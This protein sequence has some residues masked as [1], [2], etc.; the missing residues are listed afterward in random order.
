MKKLLAIVL[1][2]TLML[3]GMVMGVAAE[4]TLLSAPVDGAA[5]EITITKCEDISGWVDYT[6]EGL[7]AFE[8]TT[9]LD[10]EG[11]SAIMWKYTGV[12][13]SNGGWNRPEGATG[14][15]INWK[16]PEGAYDI[17]GMNYLVMDLYV[18]HPDLIAGVRFDVELTSSGRPDKLEN[19][20]QKTLPALAGTTLLEGWNHLEIPL[21]GFDVGKG[22][23]QLPLEPTAWNFIR[24]Y[25][26]DGF[27]T[28]GET[29]VLAVK[30]L[31]FS[32]SSPQAEAAQA[33]AQSVLDLY[34]PLADISTGDITAD[35]Y[36]TVK[37]QLEA[38]ADGYNA[39][40]DAIKFAVEEQIDVTKIERAVTRALE[41]Y[42]ESLV[43]DEPETPTEPE[44]PDEP[45]APTDPETPDEP[46]APTDP[47]TPD[48]PDAPTDPE[49]P[50]EP[51]TPDEPEKG[52]VNPIVI[53]VVA[54]VVVAAVVVVIIIVKKKQ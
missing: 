21:T 36:E 1:T 48:E 39:A 3:S 50:D 16:D 4:D 41:K 51:T 37:A 29:L 22:T 5:E 2:L 23:D 32:T 18:S 38:A 25:N 6:G 52:G 44:T 43:P 26:L 40:T 30:Y 53:V 28:L 27:D 19:S 8:L 14:V 42:E 49:T 35:N 34:A 10:A 13:H 47:E 45:D 12:V 54:V 17:S 31:G 9:E 15:K 7:P 11:A 20:A 24:M 33:A 46:D